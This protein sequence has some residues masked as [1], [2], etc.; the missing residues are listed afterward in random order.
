LTFQHSNS[1]YFLPFSRADLFVF[2]SLDCFS[3]FLF[4]SSC[5]LNTLLLLLL[6]TEKHGWACGE[7]GGGSYKE[8]RR[9]K[10][11]GDDVGFWNWL[12]TELGTATARR[13]GQI[14]VVARQEDNTAATTSGLEL[15][16]LRRK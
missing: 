14:V 8:A 1:A 7:G 2:S 9:M 10:H 11:G 15:G 5:F 16:W 13:T 6:K 12:R 4:L 3:F